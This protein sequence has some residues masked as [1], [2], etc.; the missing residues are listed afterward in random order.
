M[1]A[2]D[3]DSTAQLHDSSQHLGATQHRQTGG[4]RRAQLGVRR[5]DG[6]GR[7]DHRGVAEVGRVVPHHD[8]DAGLD[9]AA[10]VP[11]RLEVR[12]ADVHAE[13]VKH[14]GDAAHAR[15]ADADEVDRLRE[16]PRLVAH[17]VPRP[18]LVV[19]MSSTW[20]V[21]LCAASGRPSAALA[22]AMAAR[23]ALVAEQLGDET[24]QQPSAE[25]G[26]V[27]Q[28]RCA[29]GDHLPRVPAL[30]VGGGVRVRHQDRRLA[31]S[32]EL[33]DRTT[34]ARHDQIGRRH[35]GGQAVSVRDQAV[36]LKPLAAGLE[37]RPHLLLVLRPAHVHQLE[38][39][40]P[41]RRTPRHRHD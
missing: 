23:R 22:A 37:I 19:R 17:R 9:E 1:G 10:R 41:H 30:M 11:G 15:A 18:L 21:T 33:G 14:G 29:G 20:S 2:G 40:G 3:G 25:L 36:A 31:Q 4:S 32:G 39:R 35:G 38:S 27:H 28:E 6:G 12:A 26:V 13:L 5:P 34:R 8:R 24:R 16:I 7:H